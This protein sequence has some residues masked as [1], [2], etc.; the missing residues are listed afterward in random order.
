MKIQAALICS[1]AAACVALGA[2][3]KESLSVSTNAFCSQCCGARQVH[4]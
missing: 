1:V 4:R 3:A 2:Q